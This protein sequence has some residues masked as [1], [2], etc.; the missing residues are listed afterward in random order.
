MPGI[1]TKHYIDTEYFEVGSAYRL[2]IENKGYKNCILTKVTENE[3]EFAYFD[4]DNLDKI[5]L[6]TDNLMYS[7]DYQ[8][9]KL[10]C[11]YKNGKF[12]LED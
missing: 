11:D 6:N 2:K 5:V 4:K 8:I 10:E 9:Y 1:I 12:S 3:V 7:N